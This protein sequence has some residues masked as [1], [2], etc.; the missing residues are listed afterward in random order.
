MTPDEPAAFGSILFPPAAQPPAEPPSQAPDFFA[1]LN[2]DQ[3]VDGVTAGRQQ[4]ELKPLFWAPLHDAAAIGYRQEVMRDLEDLPLREK[5]KSFSEQMI[6]MRRYLRMI[7]KLNH[8]HHRTGWFLEAVQVYCGAVNRLRRDLGGAALRSG[9]LRALRDHVEAYAASQ[10]FTRLQDQAR[11]LKADL[12]AV[13]YC[14]LIKG[15]HVKV[16]RYAGEADYSAEVARTFEKFNHGAAKDYT[17]KLPPAAGMNPVEGQILAGVVKLHPELFSRLE[18]Y[19]RQNAD[20]AAE[21]LVRFDREVQ[22]YIAFLEYIAAVKKRGLAFCYP[23]MAQARQAV[24]CR[25]GFDLALARKRAAEGKPVVCNDFA[26]AGDERV[27]VVTGPN[28]GGKT[29]FARM[30]GQ[31]HY[32]AALGCPVPGRRARLFLCD[33]IFTHFEREERIQDLRGKL[34]DDL[35]RI[36]HIL[37]RATPDSILILNEIF[38]ST[39][40]RDALFLSRRMM[41]EIRRRG[42]LCVWVTFVDELASEGEKTVSMVSTVVPGHPELRTYKIVRKPADGLAYAVAIAEKYG[43]TYERIRERIGP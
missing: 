18:T 31:L 25:G 30:F 35:I 37:H 24:R 5:I 8:R 13:Q 28:Q 9:G 3:I 6:V 27:L 17:V 15:G 32:L 42:L 26:L 16:R 21:P 7:P 41:D 43:L 12:G 29:T 22:F 19:C 2:L 38:T 1:D 34:Q 33:R 4:Y 40:L 23:A 14:I 11:R 39:S 36:N 20:F 10:P